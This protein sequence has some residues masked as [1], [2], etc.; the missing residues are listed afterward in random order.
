MIKQ[1]GSIIKGYFIWIWYHIYKPYRKRIQSR[2][3]KRIKICESCE[4]FNHTFRNCEICGCFMDVKVL[5]TFDLDENG[6]SIDG[7]DQKK[8]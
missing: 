1:L 7:C 3:K 6:V 4:H 2:G 8:W 5:M